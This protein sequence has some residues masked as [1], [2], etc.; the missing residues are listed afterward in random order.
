MVTTR[1]G[2]TDVAIYGPSEVRYRYGVVLSSSPTFWAQGDSSDNIPGV[3]G[4]G[5][6]TAAK[7]AYGLRQP[8]GSTSTSTS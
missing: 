5:D 8:G 6:K 4:V 2:I 1:K 7:A 3:P